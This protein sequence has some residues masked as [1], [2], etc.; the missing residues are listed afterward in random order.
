MEIHIKPTIVLQE[1]V[2]YIASSDRARILPVK[3]IHSTWFNPVNHNNW[4]VLIFTTALSA[5]SLAMIKFDCLRFVPFSM[6]A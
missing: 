4:L 5:P 6:S 3:L 2:K 1:G